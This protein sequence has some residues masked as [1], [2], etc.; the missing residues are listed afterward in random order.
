MKPIREYLTRINH[1]FN[2]DWGVIVYL[3]PFIMFWVLYPAMRW[4]LIDAGII[5][6]VGAV[7][8]ILLSAPLEILI[9]ILIIIAIPFMWISK[10]LNGSKRK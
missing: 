8:I 10:K 6:V 3:L 5:L 1:F 9:G 4:I 7:L 2:D